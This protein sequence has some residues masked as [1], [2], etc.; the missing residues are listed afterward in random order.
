MKDQII[1]KV[2]QTIIDNHL[3]DK[4][5]CLVLGLSGG[6]DS[7]SL[8][9][10]LNALKDDMGFSLRAYHVN[11]M[12]RG[13]EADDDERY[14]K[15]L[16]EALDIP[17]DSVQIDIPALVRKNGESVEECARKE[18]QKALLSFAAKFPNSKVVL[19]HNLDDQAETVMLRL[20]RGTG[21]HGLSGM[22]Y[23][24][25]DGVIR[26]LLDVK[27][28]EIEKFCEENNIKA[29]TDSTNRQTEY[30][31]NNVRIELL[32]K[33][34]EINPNIKECLVRLASASREDDEYLQKIAEKW[35]LENCR[36]V[37]GSNGEK[38]DAAEASNE[39]SNAVE[40]DSKELLLLDKAIFQRVIKLAF[41]RIGLCEDIAAVHINALR[42]VL[43][44][45]VG[46]KLVEF[47][48]G[49]KAYLNHGTLVLSQ[50]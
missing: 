35:V 10:I 11:H 41:A 43:E 27:R 28:E 4:D 13:S 36:I 49:Y 48:N 7:V 5:D 12:I 32:P 22:E 44:A 40:I 23:K 24:R 3:V 15:D 37:E 47:P 20:L 33:L 31:R 19:A 34:S 29:H 18:R 9:H 25:A 2:K 16:C 42:T 21:V 26:P 45:N 1:K 50:K 6:P 30:L 39:K 8:L 46:N 17:F 14:A 38:R